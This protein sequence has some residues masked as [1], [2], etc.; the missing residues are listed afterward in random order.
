[1]ILYRLLGSYHTTGLRGQ[2]W[3]VE[4]IIVD[5]ASL[6]TESS[7]Y[8]LIRAFP[9]AKFALI[10]MHLEAQRILHS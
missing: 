10:G 1:M 4:R 8:C 2:L 3:D 9:Q 7:F 5:E 6:L